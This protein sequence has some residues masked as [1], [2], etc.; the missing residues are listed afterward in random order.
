MLLPLAAGLSCVLT[1]QELSPQ[2]LAN[3]G[4]TVQT[5]VLTL[6]WTLGQ[7]ATQTVNLPTGILTQGFHQPELLT[8]RPD[9]ASPT[10]EGPLITVFPNPVLAELNVRAEGFEAERYTVLQ[11]RDIRG[12]MIME[13]RN[14]HLPDGLQLNLAH[15]PAGTYTLQITQTGGETPQTFTVIKIK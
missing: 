14:A 11:L 1:A 15:L 9:N 5:S 12:R 13:R 7:L 10:D 4:G 2:V 8:V 6:D 3:G